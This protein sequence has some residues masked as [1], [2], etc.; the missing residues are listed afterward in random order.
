M[1][2]SWKLKLGIVIFLM[3]ICGCT[4][5]YF[6]YYRQQ[7]MTLNGMLQSYIE[8]Y[9]V[10]EQLND[11][12]A[13]ITVQAPDFS[14]LI[15]KVSGEVDYQDVSDIDL[16]NAVKENPELVKQYTM[17]VEKLDKENIEKAFSSQIAYELLI[18]AIEQSGENVEEEGQ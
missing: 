17:S 3:V 12:S 16:A 15:L 2:K 9:N 6:L 7:N 10:E 4:I 13:I 1:K 8:D 18:Q 11:G 5:V 14:Q